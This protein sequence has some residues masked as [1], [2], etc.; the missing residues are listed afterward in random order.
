[1]AQM[2]QN[3]D[4]HTRFAENDGHLILR[5]LRLMGM[6]DRHEI[7]RHFRYDGGRHGAGKSAVRVGQ[8]DGFPARHGG[9]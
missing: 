1:V 9:V 5:V 4:R 3:H 8:A 7:R 6:W 2:T